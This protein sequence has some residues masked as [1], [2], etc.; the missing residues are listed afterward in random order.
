MGSIARCA[1]KA[2]RQ[3]LPGLR[4]AM[5]EAYR[6]ATG[7]QPLMPPF[8][9][10]NDPPGPAGRSALDGSAQSDH[11]LL[12]LFDHAQETTRAVLNRLVQYRGRR[13]LFDNYAIIH[14]QDAIGDLPGESY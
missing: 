6:S 13:S 1:T 12:A 8:G 5:P 4:H 11:L 3:R 14:E 2:A 9:S 10:G 7:K